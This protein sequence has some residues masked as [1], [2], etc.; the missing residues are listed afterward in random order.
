MNK[1]KW[2]FPIFVKIRP[3]LIF[4]IVCIDKSRFI[5]YTVIVLNKQ[6]FCYLIS[7]YSVTLPTG[8]VLQLEFRLCVDVNDSVTLPTGKVLQLRPYIAC[9]PTF[10]SATLRNGK[11]LQQGIDCICKSRNSATLRNGKVLQP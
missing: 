5:C 10:H 4:F 2:I 8:K 3:F 7:W 9:H 1:T 11:V 6:H